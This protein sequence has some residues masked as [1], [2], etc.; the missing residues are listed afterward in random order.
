MFLSAYYEHNRKLFS[1]DYVDNASYFFVRRIFAPV[2]PIIYDST[3]SRFCQALSL[4]IHFP[5]QPVAGDRF[6]NPENRKKQ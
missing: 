4:K 2:D 6:V 5:G 3:L 1:L